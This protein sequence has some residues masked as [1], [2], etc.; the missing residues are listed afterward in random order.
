MRV[1]IPTRGRIGDQTTLGGLSKKM[2]ETVV[3]LVCPARE[4]VEHAARWPGVNVV[5]QPDP[6]M[7]IAAK[8]AWIMR[9]WRDA[10][11]SRI[12]MLDDDQ[13]WYVRRSDDDWH[14]V[15][16]SAEQVEHWFDELGRVLGPEMPHAGF[17]PR[18]GN[19]RKPAGWSVPDRMMYSLGYYLPV[20]VKE[21]ELGRIEHREDMD[22]TLQLLRKG[23]PNA[24]CHSFVGN[25]RA[26][27][28]GGCT[29]QRTVE[30]SNSDAR[31]LAEL[32][33]G[34]VRVVEKQYKSSV[35]RLE[36]VCQWARALRD[37]QQWRES[38]AGGN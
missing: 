1:V 32:H 20:V 38:R 28:R 21:C 4:A 22:Y 8:R 14:L 9:E 2:R 17:G 36:V 12:V 16:A 26:F 23:Y 24:V 29:G 27:S 37:G 34:Y 3:D 15:Q 10:G 30:A 31:L 35:P 13:S 18:Q 5:A 7:T 11:H 6:D 25:Q 19:N 33:P